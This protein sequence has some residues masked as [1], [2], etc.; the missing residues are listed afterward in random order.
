MG[1][2]TQTI[3]ETN[4]DSVND[5]ATAA[6]ADLLS[7][8]KA[9][10]DI[11]RNIDKNGGLLKLDDNGFIQQK[12][13]KAGGQGVPILRGDGKLNVDQLPIG[14]GLEKGQDDNLQHART[15]VQA[16]KRAAAGEAITELILDRN[17][18]VIG[19]VVS[20][21]AS[22]PIRLT[23]F[24]YTNWFDSQVKAFNSLG[25]VAYFNSSVETR[26]VNTGKIE[27]RCTGSGKGLNCGNRAVFRTDYRIKYKKER[28]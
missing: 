17:G 2:P 15:A 4:L 23:G 21:I 28:T 11:I 7:A 8:V 27:Y 19:A 16:I 14:E 25:G 6:R 5:S 18:H 1:I 12:N 3:R 10:N 13:L 20:R 24:L 26:R 9:L 22:A